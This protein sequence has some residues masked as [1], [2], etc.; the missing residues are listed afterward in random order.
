MVRT[1]TP[2]RAAWAVATVFFMSGF[3]FASWASRLP[4][5]RDALGFDER[6][7][8]LLLLSAAIGSICALPLSGM[9]VHRIGAVRTVL[10]FAVLT[11]VGFAVAILAVQADVHWAVRVGLLLAGAGNGVWDAAMNIE[12]AAVERRLG[13]SLM[14]RLHAAFSL[15]TVGG[16]GVGALAAYMHISYAAH[17]IGALL[18]VVLIVVLAVQWFLP[19]EA[20]PEPAPDPQADPAI[21]PSAGRSQLAAWTEGRTLL[22]GVIVLAAALTE[23]AANDWVSLAIVDGFD[24][25]DGTGALGLAIFLSAM[26]GMRL[27][28]TG[29]LDRF[30]RVAVLRLSAGLALVGLIIFATVNSLPVA[31][32][33]IVLWGAGAALGFP[34]GMSAASDDPQ[35]AAMR[36]SVVA[37]IGYSAFFVGPPL[38]GFLA[39]AVGYR[40]ALL[41]I[42]IPL[43]LGLLVVSAARPPQEQHGG[44]ADDLPDRATN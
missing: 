10:V 37:T 26:T 8:G 11:A 25:D 21:A 43:V 38:I 5:I 14:P 17:E 19:A 31:M 24:T 2:G 44:E 42:A 9:V 27:L 4:A 41:V 1:L 20:T 35:H 3:A 16:A 6:E 18:F 22:I 40:Q 23:G 34:V 39:H 36:V 15:G 33:G 29:L 12:G 28:G 7:M 32:V 13:R 30:G